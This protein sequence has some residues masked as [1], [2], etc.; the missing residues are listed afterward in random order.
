M[1]DEVLCCA[2][3]EPGINYTVLSANCPVQPR[4][5]R[6]LTLVDDALKANHREQTA[7]HCGAGNEAED[8]DSEQAPRVGAARLLQE[9]AFLC[10]SHGAKREVVE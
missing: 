3:I 2:E 4:A 7:A 6:L 1:L 5:R 8:N 10:S 9:L